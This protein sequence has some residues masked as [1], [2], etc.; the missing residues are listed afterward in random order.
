MTAS[1]D[2]C[3]GT[4]RQRRMLRRRK[5]LAALIGVGVLLA[6]IVMLSSSLVLISRYASTRPS[7]TPT[8]TLSATATDREVLVALFH[9]TNGRRWLRRHGWLSDAAIG[10]WYGV[11]T[12][13]SGRVTALHLSRNHLSGSLPPEIVYLDSLATL[14]I[15]SSEL[16]G[17]VPIWLGQLPNLRHLSLSH[18]EFSGPI[19]PELGNLSSLISLDLSSN[20][21]SGS[22]PPELSNLNNLV[23]LSVTFNELTGTIPKAL[24]NLSRLKLLDFS[25]NRLN[26]SIPPELGNLARLESLNLIY[27]DLMCVQIGNPLFGLRIAYCGREGETATIQLLYCPAKSRFQTGFILEAFLRRLKGLTGTR[28]TREITRDCVRLGKK[29]WAQHG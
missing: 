4:E 23:S 6:T 26:G 7:R 12:D 2:L 25:H 17:T 16:G 9:A 24:Q 22:I 5:A 20:D 3:Q 8:P 1:E 14:S 11:T 18:G 29:F 15:G 10:E 13:E 28:V 19:P 21:L 27:N